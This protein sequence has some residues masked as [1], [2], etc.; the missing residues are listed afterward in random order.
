M[1]LSFIF[2]V[3]DLLTLLAYPLVFVYARFR[4]QS[5]QKKGSRL[6]I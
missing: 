3:M 2:V 1:R 6:P 5:N 4:Q